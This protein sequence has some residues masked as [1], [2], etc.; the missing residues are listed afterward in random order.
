MT[1]SDDAD[2]KVAEFADGHHR[3]IVGAR[4]F[5]AMPRLC[6]E[7]QRLLE[8]KFHGVFGTDISCRV[9]RSSRWNCVNPMPSRSSSRLGS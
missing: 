1:A 5:D 4:D 2:E 7:V 6:G 3:S 8:T 9:V